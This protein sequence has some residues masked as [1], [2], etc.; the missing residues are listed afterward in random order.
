[1]MPRA[2]SN[3][4]IRWDKTGEAYFCGGEG[5][6]AVPMKMHR[7]HRD[8]LCE[9]LRKRQDLTDTPDA[10]IVLEGGNERSMYD[11][12]VDWDLF[13]QE[14]NFQYLFGVKE[15]GCLGFIRISDARTIL[16]VP[17]FDKSYE[18]W[19]GPIKPPAWFQRAYAVNEVHFVDESKEVLQSLS[20]KTTYIIDGENRDS[21]LC[22]PPPQFDGKDAFEVSSNGSKALWEE[23]GECR[24]VKSRDELKIMQYVNDV[25]SLAHISVMR[26]IRSGQ[27]EMFS[28]ATFRYQSALRACNRVG[29]SCI[30][31]VGS[32]NAILHYGHPAE[33]NA[34]LVEAG[35]LTLH[36]MGCEYHCYTADVTVTFPVNGTFT[37]PQRTVYEAV[38]AA[39]LAVEQTI[40]PGVSY[41]GMHRLAQRTLVTHMIDA[42][43]FCGE[44]GEI[45]EADVIGNFMP[46]GLGHSLGLDVHDVGGYAPGTFR[47]DDP[48]ITQNLR[49]GRELIEGMVIT[50]EPGFYF[51]DYLMEELLTTPEKVRF[52][53][54]AK[55]EELRPVG[56]VRIE[57]DV[58]ITATGCR[59][60]TCVPRAVADIEAVMA[61]HEWVVSTANG[62]EY[63]GSAM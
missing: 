33:P 59:V 44:V 56:G 14:S 46:H 4:T 40:R 5:A 13:R 48:S 52:V 39:V 60:L 58:V 45:M 29:Y 32:R 17:R 2:P 36:D 63:L 3:G 15:P 7:E 61:G 1:V 57:D 47:K 10:V 42:G 26:G 43:L 24:V 30:C 18:A 35:A 55:L 21:G 41:K 51:A 62:R 28:E 8:R 16:L 34:E 6:P 20:P 38:W 37:A 50:V 9:R 54:T 53:N 49:C 11:T 27:R 19:M 31:P 25:S 12:D 22:L 23:L